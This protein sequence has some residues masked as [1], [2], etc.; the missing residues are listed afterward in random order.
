MNMLGKTMAIITDMDI[1]LG[2][3]VG[4]SLELLKQLKL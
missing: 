3:A 1:P 4:N 2:S